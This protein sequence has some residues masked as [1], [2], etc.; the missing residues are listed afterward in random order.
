MGGAPSPAPEPA[1]PGRAPSGIRPA[2]T[3]SSSRRFRIRSASR[4]RWGSRLLLLALLGACTPVGS[5]IGDPVGAPE[6]PALAPP[7]SS[8]GSPARAPSPPGAYR[9][10]LRQDEFT[11]PLRDGPLQIKVTPL[12]EEVITLAAPDTYDRLSALLESRRAEASRR[13]G[14]DAPTLFL[15]SLFSHEPDTRFQAEDL[16]LIHQGRLLR[17]RAILPLTP[18]WSGA[19][20]LGRQATESAIYVF[21]PEIDLDQPLV[22]RYGRSESDAWA[23]IILRLR[24]ERARAGS[25]GNPGREG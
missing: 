25:S 24:A 12:A 22:V 4:A 7:S 17:P 2:R 11:V 16:H 9:G 3:S 1:R 6:G 13:T 23:R 19:Q 21:D 20:R 5:P 8:P 14:L 15:V 18:G 10:T